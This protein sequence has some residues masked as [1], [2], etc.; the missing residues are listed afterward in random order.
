MAGIVDRSEVAQF[1]NTVFH[2]LV[3]DDTLVELVT[4]LHHAMTHSVDFLQTLD[5][6]DLRIKQGLE[7]KVHTF[8]VVGHV[9]HDHFFLATWQ[10]HLDKSVVDADALHASLGQH[11]LIV[12]VVE[13]V[14]DRTTAAV[15]D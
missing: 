11:R 2:A 14:L 12:H 10:R 7:D 3:D 8:L 13:L 15:Q 1:F 9:V 4:A 6:P 5:G